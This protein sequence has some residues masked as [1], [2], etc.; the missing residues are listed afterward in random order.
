MP[1]RRAA[2]VLALALLAAACA[3]DAPGPGPT[4]GPGSTTTAHAP[5]VT[6]TTDA[7]APTTG[8]PP[9]V[10][11]DL[12]RVLDGDTLLAAIEGREEEVRLLGINTPEPG[13]C[14]AR[15][16]RGAATA[17]LGGTPL[18]VEVV[19][20]RDQYG[21]LLG[22]AYAGGVPVNRQLL[23]GGYALAL[24]TDHPRRA[25]FLA[26]EEAAFAAGA[27]L[28]APDACGPPTPNPPFLVEVAADPPG[29]DEDDLNGEWVLFSGNGISV[30][31]LTGWV[32]R[33][34]SSRHR[35]RFP[36][37]FL[38]NPGEGVAV[39]TGCGRDGPETLYWC[40]DGPVWNNGGDAAL[41]LDPAGNVAARLRYPG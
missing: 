40:A 5:G 14:F 33:D 4:S 27:G 28:W 1:A 32:L 7:G 17:M 41:L 29:P 38:L 18:A 25:E 34:E 30:L 12:I 21:R 10:A 23:D 8:P 6:T 3:D 35:Y 19:G 37:G 16:A 36:D 9:G 15:Q 26:A 31:D 11:A 2:A 13:E 24:D 20:G 22:Y 39:F